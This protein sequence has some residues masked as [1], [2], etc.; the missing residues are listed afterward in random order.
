MKKV[1]S[2]IIA[3]S[4]SFASF[5]QLL[6]ED[7]TYTAGQ[8]LSANGWTAY[9]GA[10]TNAL[11]V[12]APGLTYTGHPGSGVGNAVT[13]TN[14]G[15]DAN[16][17]LSSAVTT[18]NAYMSFMVNISAVQTGDYFIGLFQSTSI[19]PLRVYVKSDGAGGFNF[20]VSKGSSTVSYETTSRTLGTT[21]FVA[22]K[23]TFNSATTTDDVVDLWV[24]PA[25]GSTETTATIAGVTGAATDAT[26]IGAV[27][28]RQGGSA[29]ASSQQ[30]D[31]LLAG[32]TW[33]SVTAGTAGPTPT[34]SLGTINTFGSITTGSNSTSQT[35]SLSG[36]NLTG[37]PGNITITSPNTDFQVSSDNTT[38]GATATIPFTSATLAATSFYVRFTPQTNGP[39]SGNVTLVGGG[40]TASLSVSGTGVVISAPVATSATTVGGTG[41]T[42]NWNAVSGATAYLLDVY[43]KT[44]GLVTETI[45]GWN[46]ATNTVASQTADVGNTNNS[47][48]QTISLQGSTGTISYQS[49]PSGAIGVPNPFSVSANGWDNGQDTKYWQV[50]VNTTGAT[51][52]TVSSLQG[53]SNTGPKDF[54]LQYKIGAA[55]TWTDVAAGTVTL[56]T[57]VLAGDLTTWGALNNVALPAAADNQSLVSLR[58]IMNSNT[59]INASPVAAGGTSRISAIYIKGQVN[60]FINNYV[61]QNTNVSNVTSYAVTGLTANTTYYYVVRATNGVS[62]SVN[63][64]EITVVTNAAPTLSATTLAAYGV[65]TSASPNS[66]TLTGSNLSSANI[67][68]GPLAGYAFGTSASGPFQST[69]TLTQPG[70][71]YSQAVFVQF[72]PTAVQSYNGNI[73]VSGGGASV[74]TVAAT[75]SGVNTLASVSGGAASSITQTSATVSGT[76]SSIGCSAVTAYGIEYS[77]TAGFANGTGTAVASSN[78]A[79][80]TFSSALSGLAPATTYYYHAYATNA[81]GT[82]YTS[83]QS[84]TT[85]NPNPVLSANTLTGFGSVC[86][87]TSS[88]ANSFT[89]TGT[90]LTTANVVVG[91]LSGYTFSTAAAGTYSGTLTIPQPG[92]AFS[93]AVF[94]KLTPTAVQSYNGNI[95]VSGGGAAAS[96]NVTVTGGGISTAP[97]VTTGAAS[98]ITTTGATLAGSITAT[99]CT[100]VT[101]Y[102]V[103]YST[104]NGFAN[105]S[106]TQA[107]STNLNAGSYTSTLSGLTPATTYYYKA[108]AT[109][110]GGTTY[111]AQQS[112][113]T[114]APPP[115][116]L[117]VSTLTAFGN[118]C[119]NGLVGP[120]T[121][122]IT[123]SNLTSALITV[124]PLAGYSFSETQT[125]SY[126]NTIGII[127]AGGS[128][129]KT[130]FVRFNPTAAQSYNGSVPVS[131]GGASTVFVVASGAGVNTPA[132]VTTGGSS[133]LTTSSAVLAGT[134]TGAGCSSVTAYGIE[135][136][137]ISGFANGAGTKMPS[138]NLSGAAFTS[139]VS[140]LL[141][142]ATYYYKAYVTT[143]GGTAYGQQ[144]SFT[145]SAI[146]AGY[147]IF[148]SPARPGESV[149][150][151][152]Q[153]TDLFPGY[154]GL[155]FFDAMG[156]MVYVHHM[157]VQA[158]FIDRSVP[159]PGHMPLGVYEVRLVNFEKELGRQRI[160]IQ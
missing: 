69:L 117:T 153:L 62:T 119:V 5:G 24:N 91:P 76:I 106:G 89:V 45:A 35:V 103:E 61:Q 141:Q 147:R 155:Q 126:N 134:I 58:W 125:G 120:N 84:F 118:V 43:S 40:A 75:G 16:R 152:V 150:L 139:S 86:I 87:N 135:Y 48:I 132:T 8:L 105:G 74:I 56:T 53:S 77:T 145:L 83:E 59:A 85:T 122:T 108:Y 68:V 33:A 57:A 146:G 73:P 38:F 128:L 50:D 143:S 99:G 101:A 39:K 80:G 156:R 9:S 93:Q 66:F 28:I 37:A 107:A 65:N 133:N 64:N 21:Y 148:P 60:G 47:G 130:I 104:I 55:G 81:G 94:V 6:T 78:L 27:M 32:I 79:A 46:C 136:S 20:G 109:N 124:G 149:K 67:V 158:N 71:A 159:L 112:F 19:F 110:S 160:I 97:S 123:G 140:G 111:G 113:T 154:Y 1:L 63:S 26:T 98:S 22:V 14:T 138:T 115:P 82:A 10:G 34:F 18:G 44:P 30:V 151:T 31:A 36:T 137:S 2:L 72:N 25:L 127:Q 102:G 96:I 49:G 88:T 11:T 92:G 17:T 70:G 121:F 7:F 12:T 142:G 116:Q 54:K 15:E 114:T 157:N 52:I 51:N 4:L 29:S 42:A 144:Q 90:N 100:V 41:F 13:M 23:Y 3:A 131:G 129:S 95:P